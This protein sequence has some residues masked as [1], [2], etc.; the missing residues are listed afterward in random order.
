MSVAR[1]GREMIRTEKAGESAG[2]RVT[3]VILS[4]SLALSL[5]SVCLCLSLLSLFLS[6][7]LSLSVYIYSKRKRTLSG[8]PGGVEIDFF[9]WPFLRGGSCE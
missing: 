9:L 8:P 5:L 2:T 4:L 7:P 3:E 1:S 6:L